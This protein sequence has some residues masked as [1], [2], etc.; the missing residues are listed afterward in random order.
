MEKTTK[1]LLGKILGELYENQGEDC[2]VCEGTIYGLKNGFEFVLDE[3]INDYKITNE[4]YKNF[5]D[6]L[7]P[8]FY[9]EKKLA[10]F[11]GYYDIENEMNNVGIDRVKAI[12]LFTYFK[13]KG[14]FAELISKLDSGA[15]PT[16]LRTF[17]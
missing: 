16:E 6:I 15:S 5:V 17:D 11:K 14:G 1:I 13:K 3:I 8:I 7:S 12:L 10:Q 9:D 4:D 2:A